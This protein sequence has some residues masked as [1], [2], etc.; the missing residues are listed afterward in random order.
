MTVAESAAAARG[1]VR[2]AEALERAAEALE[3]IAAVLDR[4]EAGAAAGAVDVI[5]ACAHP[6]TARA[7][8]SVMGRERWVC[9]DCGFSVDRPFGTAEG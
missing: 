5:E 8:A 3:R 4:I 6:L 2:Q 7:D 1:Q 9:R